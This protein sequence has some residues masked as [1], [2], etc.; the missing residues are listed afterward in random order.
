METPIQQSYLLKHNKN[1]LCYFEWSPLWPYGVRVQACS[2]RCWQRRR[3]R[4]RRELHLCEHLETLTWQVGEKQHTKTEYTTQKK[5]YHIVRYASNN[6]QPTRTNNHP[7]TIPS[8]FRLCVHGIEGMNP[9]DHQDPAD[10]RVPDQTG[11]FI[12]FQWDFNGIYRVSMSFLMVFIGF[13][14][15]FNGIWWDLMG[16]NGI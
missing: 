4:R 8:S 13:Q 5:T 10:V 6:Y 16:F 12:G 9:F 11:W 3:R 2:I 1:K 14:W 15:D 7:T